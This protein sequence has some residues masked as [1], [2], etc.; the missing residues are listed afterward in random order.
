MLTYPDID[1]VALSLGPLQI[2]WY[3]LMYLAGFAAAWLLGRWRASRPGSGWTPAMVD[4]VIFY[5]VIGVIAGGR[6]GYMLFYGFDQIL[7]N[8]LNLLKVWQGGMSFHGGLIGV[9]IAMALFARKHHLGLFQVG[10]FVAPLV[11]LG[12]FA[13]RI[14]NFINGELWGHV[15]DLAWGM[16]LPCARFPEACVALPADAVLSPP[17]HASQ[18]YEAGLEGLVLFVVLWWFSSRP[19]PMMAVTG[20]FLLLYGVF[21]FA[22]EFVRVPDAHI[23]YLAFDWL[24][25]GQVLTLPMLLAGALLLGIAYARRGAGTQSLAP[26]RRHPAGD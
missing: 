18:L 14:G 3:G 26:G 5:C 20:L 23:G 15:T 6:L 17:V 21:R 10:D 16:R 8:P 24:T 7:D 9:T 13:G 12:L 11:P 19:R 25:M 2:H 1:P 22:V 4:D